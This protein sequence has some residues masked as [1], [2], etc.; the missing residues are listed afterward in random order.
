MIRGKVLFMIRTAEGKVAFHGP[1]T[2][3]I[4][5]AYE[6]G[7]AYREARALARH[8]A[9]GLTANRHGGTRSERLAGIT[10]KI[11]ETGSLDKT[12]ANMVH[13]VASDVTPKIVKLLPER[14][15]TSNSKQWRR[16]DSNPRPEMFRDKLLHA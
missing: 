7:A 13:D 6:A 10:E 14:Q 3:L 8:G 12:G 9:P 2:S 16:G 5:P 15:L 4:A 1:R 11:A